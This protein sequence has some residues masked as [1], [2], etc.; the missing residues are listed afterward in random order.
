[1]RKLAFLC[2]G[3]SLNEVS[4][5]SIGGSQGSSFLLGLRTSSVEGSGHYCE[6]SVLRS[7]GLNKKL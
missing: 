6:P 5:D 1:M 4:E 3:T 7:P 2:P